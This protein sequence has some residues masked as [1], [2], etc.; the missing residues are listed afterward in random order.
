MLI[1]ENVTPGLYP[2]HH[3]LHGRSVHFHPKGIFRHLFLIVGV[4]FGL[5]KQHSM[6]NAEGLL[7]FLGSNATG[8]LYA[9]TGVFTA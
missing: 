2:H 1:Y 7:I 8:E 3:I 9:V 6:V 5:L 4:L